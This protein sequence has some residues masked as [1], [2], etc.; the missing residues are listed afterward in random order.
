MAETIGATLAQNQIGVIYGGAKIGIMGAVADGS[1]TH[2]EVIG[3]LPHFSA[4]KKL[5][6]TN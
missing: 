6:T 4:S 1:I 5:L 3:I 2:G